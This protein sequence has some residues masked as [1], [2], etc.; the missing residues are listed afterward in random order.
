[1]SVHVGLD[2]AFAAG[3]VRTLE[4]AAGLRPRWHRRS[5]EGVQKQAQAPRMVEG[6]SPALGGYYLSSMT[7]LISSEL[8]FNSGAYM[9]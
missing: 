3:D 7:S 9:A 8:A 1:M 5:D 4:L 2:A 6:L